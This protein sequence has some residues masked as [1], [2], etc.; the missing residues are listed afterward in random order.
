MNW[1]RSFGSRAR[2]GLLVGFA[3]LGVGCGTTQITTSD[4]KAKIF[5]DGQL[6]GEGSAEMRRMGPP[7]TVELVVSQDGQEV[8]KTEVKRE[9]TAMTLLTGMLTLYTGLFWGWQFP[10]ELNYTL[11]EARAKTGGDWGG[12]KSLWM[13][14]AES[15]WDRPPQPEPVQE[16]APTVPITEQ[17]TE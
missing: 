6:L 3:L 5:V 10:D 12:S 13:K 9:F 7:K 15:P 4:P 2:L 14:E 1:N 17:P 8:V 11:P 16:P